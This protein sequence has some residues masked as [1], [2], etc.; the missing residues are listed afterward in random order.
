MRTLAVRIPVT[1]IMLCCDLQTMPYECLFL[2]FQRRTGIDIR[3]GKNIRKFE[4][5]FENFD[6]FWSDSDGKKTSKMRIS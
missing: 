6:D 3:A 1:S 2:H 5:G 4:D